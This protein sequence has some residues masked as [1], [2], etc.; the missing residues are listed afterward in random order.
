MAALAMGDN[1]LDKKQI[2]KIFKDI[3]AADEELAKLQS[4]HMIKCKQ[5]RKKI[6]DARKD[7]KGLGLDMTAFAVAIKNWRD[8]QRIEHRRAELE[9]GEQAALDGIMA[10]LGD[11]ASTELGAAAIRKAADADAL[12]SLS[13]E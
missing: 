8:R 5:P 12:E 4:E 13:E 6:R 2:A 7:A 1:S 11:Y 3:D 10:A 9:P